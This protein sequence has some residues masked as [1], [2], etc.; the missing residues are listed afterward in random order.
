MTIPKNA[1]I[2]GYDAIL[3]RHDVGGIDVA[4]WTVA[5]LERHV[6]RRALLA[7]ED[8]AVPLPAR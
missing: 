1:C 2:A 8:A 5:D 7:A 4:L 3:T 6:D